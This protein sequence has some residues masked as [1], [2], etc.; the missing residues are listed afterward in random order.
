MN[1]KTL[2]L[3]LLTTLA[4]LAPVAQ[5]GY[6][7]DGIQLMDG[8]DFG[9]ENTELATDMI[10]SLTKMGI[11]VVDGG[12]NELPICIPDPEAGSYTLGY[13]VPSQ[14]YVVICT[15]VANKP[16][17]FETLTHEVVH[18]IQD[19]RVGIDNGALGDGDTTGILQRISRNKFNAVTSLYPVDHHTVEFEA[20]HY[21]DQPMVVA[22]ELRRW[23]F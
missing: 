8:T 15:N 9:T 23:A 2:G 13:Y 6:V 21:Q 19:A 7:Y 16:R 11:P 1:F 22:N 12:K 3:G 18:V 4:T 14:N 10:N 17:Q 5:A 20:F